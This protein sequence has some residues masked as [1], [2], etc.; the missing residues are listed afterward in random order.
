MMT[1]NPNLAVSRRELRQFGLGLAL[2]G[3]LVGGVLLWKG[4]AAGAGVLLLAELAG[5]AFWQV[6]PGVRSVY[7][8]WMKLAAVMAR[9]MTTLLLTLLYLLV[10]TP[11]ALLGRAFGQRFVE[12]G[13]RET[14]DSY[15]E[16]RAE[17]DDRRSCERQS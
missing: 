10:L 16:P 9:I 8:G 14:R 2:L 11:I 12:R 1:V 17:S 6:W 13:F 3:G 15:W 7:A 5:L 4:Q